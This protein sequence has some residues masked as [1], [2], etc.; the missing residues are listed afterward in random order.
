MERQLL[1]DRRDL[2]ATDAVERLVGMQA[3][4]PDDPYVGLWSRLVDFQPE[5]LAD[6]LT[7]RRVVRASLL[8]ATIHLVTA[9]DY[10]RLRPVV[11]P[12]L[13]RG[14]YQNAARREQL[15]G[16]DVDAVVAAGRKYL[17]DG[18]LTQAELGRPLGPRW[19]DADP[20][21][22]AFAVRMLTPVVFTPPRGVWGETGPAA[23]TTAENWLGEAVGTDADPDDAIRGTSRRSAPRRPPTCG[24][25]QG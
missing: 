16:V 15:D 14:V 7:G 17:A 8:R 6:L 12:V 4:N 18:P 23:M 24:P 19:P 22:L 10:L 13:K 1:L 2:P 11:G 25:G 5:E 21:A 9:E 20:A 3:Q